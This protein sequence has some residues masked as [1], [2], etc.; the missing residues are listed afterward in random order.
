LAEF[1]GPSL[2]EAAPLI[3]RFAREP[4]FLGHAPVAYFPK[5]ALN[6]DAD[7][8]DDLRRLQGAFDDLPV[9]KYLRDN[10]QFRYRRFGR[11]LWDAERPLAEPRWLPHQAY[12]Q[13]TALNRYAG[14]IQRE[15]PPLTE[16]ITANRL[17]TRL[18]QTLFVLLPAED[19]R[20]A[21]YWEAGLHP[22]RVTATVDE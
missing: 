21:K 13:S 9:D 5:S 14:G 20:R 2:P 10:A 3:W 18:L 19:R 17:V 8:R 15:F 6:L 1:T 11:A 4:A 16:H 22:T 12:F 7:L